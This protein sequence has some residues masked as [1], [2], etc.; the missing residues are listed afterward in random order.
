[1][2]KVYKLRIYPNKS[3]TKLINKTLDCYRWVSNKYLE[4]EIRHYAETGKFLSGYEFSKK[5]NNLKK[6][7]DAYSWIVKYNAHAINHAIFDKAEAFKS[8]F[9]RHNGFPKLNQ[10]RNKLVGHYILIN[11]LFTIPI[12][13]TSLNYL[14]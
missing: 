8:F 9:K 5:I 7:S 6:T 10:K 2:H 11:H 14:Y 4:E 13:K 3:Q 1:M 12:I